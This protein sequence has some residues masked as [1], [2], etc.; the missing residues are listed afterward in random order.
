MGGGQVQLRCR[1]LWQCAFAAPTKVK[2]PVARRLLF[3]HACAGI[4]H[5]ASPGRRPIRSWA[6]SRKGSTEICELIRVC[7]LCTRENVLH[8]S[9][10]EFWRGLIMRPQT[11][12]RGPTASAGTSSGG[13]GWQRRRNWGAMNARVSLTDVYR[14]K[15]EWVCQL[16]MPR[17]PVTPRSCALQKLRVNHGANCPCVVPRLDN[18]DATS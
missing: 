12:W 7:A 3:G 4:C 13:R 18:N 14:G 15:D 16:S 8:K 2:E 17:V 10:M 11:W 6:W 9:K 1:R 5:D